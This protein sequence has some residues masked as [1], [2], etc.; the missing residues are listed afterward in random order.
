MPKT[1]VVFFRGPNGRAPA[2]EG[3]RD[4]LRRG[5]RR[6]FAKCYVRI[7]RLAQFGHELRRPEAD[8]LR[9]GIHELRA[10]CGRV[11]YRL[12]YFFHE[13][14]A[15]LTQLIVKEGEVPRIEIE[16]AIAFKREFEADPE[17]RSLR[18]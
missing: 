14:R 7:S 15:V 12:L 2:Y 8:L 5:E 10:T 9:D 11:H 17:E 16:R 4:L 1:D 6:A 13:R 3:L 18:A